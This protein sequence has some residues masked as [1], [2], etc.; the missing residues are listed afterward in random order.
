[1]ETPPT[2]AAG[3]AVAQPS[4]PTTSGGATGN[5]TAGSLLAGLAFAVGSIAVLGL[6][7]WWQLRGGSMKAATGRRVSATDVG[8]VAQ[9]AATTL[10]CRACGRAAK[11]GERLERSVSSA[12]PRHQPLYALTHLSHLSLVKVWSVPQREILLA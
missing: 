10:R 4:S 8:A 5:G 9:E 3:G 6:A 1:M 11:E 7:T 12:S 2:A